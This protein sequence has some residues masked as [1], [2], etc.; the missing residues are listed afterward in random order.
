MKTLLPLLLALLTL[1]TACKSTYKA[2]QKGDYQKAVFNSLDRLKKSPNNRKSREALREAYPALLSYV[3][4]KIDQD[5]LSND[6]LKWEKVIGH[7]VLLNRVYDEIRTTPAARD[8]IRSPQNFNAELRT[9]KQN[10]AAARYAMGTQGLNRGRRGDREAA[11]EAY[12]HFAKADEILPNYR[13]AR[14]L[15]Q[16]S[17]EYA[18]LFV[19]IE[20]IPMHSQTFGLTNAFFESQLNE[21]FVVTSLSP[22]VSFYPGASARGPQGGPD[23][24]LRMRFDDFVVGQAYVKEKEVQRVQENVVLEERKVSEDSVELIYGTVKATVHQFTQEIVSSGLLDVQIIDARTGAI[25]AQRKFPGTYVWSDYW[26]YFNGDERALTDEDRSYTRKRGQATPPPPQAL[27]VEFTK[28][29][30]D[31]V[32]SFVR[33]Y[34]RR[35]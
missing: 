14:Q 28:P 31:Q 17:R 11:K 23:H 1:G 4:E 2:Y 12:F 3:Q 18:T 22:F 9:A 32:V 10:A 35:A 13:D 26:G 25:I 29:I 24:I 27:F 6:P 34:Y 15:A 19:E 33:E 7:Y 5:K 21:A 30:Y 8:I 16:E 20:P